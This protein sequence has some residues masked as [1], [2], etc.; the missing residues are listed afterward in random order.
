MKR[1]RPY[2]SYLAANE[3]R[4]TKSKEGSNQPAPAVVPKAPRVS[5]PSHA[6]ISSGVMA[7]SKHRSEN[8]QLRRLALALG[9][10]RGV[11]H[12]MKSMIT[13]NIIN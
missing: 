4:E 13:I 7:A 10:R 8:A 2:H 3:M 1:K 6:V 12:D 11:A 5:W 9:R